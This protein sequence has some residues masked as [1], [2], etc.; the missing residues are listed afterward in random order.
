MFWSV[1][2]PTFASCDSPPVMKTRALI[3]LFGK[4]I[5]NDDLFFAFHLSL[6]LT[7]EHLYG[8][9]HIQLVSNYPSNNLQQEKGKRSFTIMKI[10]VVMWQ[11]SSLV[12]YEACTDGKTSVEG[13]S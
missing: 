2:S 12:A 6:L 1:L 5:S 8:L 10:K 13:E 4:F 7:C 9:H 3:T 11:T